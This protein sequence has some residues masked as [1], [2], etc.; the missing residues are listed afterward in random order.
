MPMETVQPSAALASVESILLEAAEVAANMAK[1]SEHG[2][3]YVLRDPL[4]RIVGE[5]RVQDGGVIFN[6]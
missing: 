3:A 1:H 4:Q 6:R 5:I 2:D